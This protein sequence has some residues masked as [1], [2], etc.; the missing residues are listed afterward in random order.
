M[1]KPNPKCPNYQTAKRM[2]AALELC[3]QAT[4]EAYAGDCTP[5]KLLAANRSARAAI[6]DADPDNE[7]GR[8]LPP[9]CRTLDERAALISQAVIDSRITR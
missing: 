1:L 8:S 5:A 9:D 7:I 4:G 6:F 3:W 2:L